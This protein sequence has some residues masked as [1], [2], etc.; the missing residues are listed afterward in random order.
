M[1]DLPKAAIDWLVTAPVLPSTQKGW[2][3]QEVK[4]AILTR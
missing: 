3:L 4:N 2:D 1:G